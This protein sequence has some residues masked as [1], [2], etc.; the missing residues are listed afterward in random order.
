ME[1]LDKF[2]QHQ[3]YTF[4]QGAF[5]G[6]YGTPSLVPFLLVTSTIM[7]QM[8]STATVTADSLPTEEVKTA[9]GVSERGSA[10]CLVQGSTGL[11][12]EYFVSLAGLD[13][14]M[15]AGMNHMACNNT[16]C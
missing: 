2:F 15:Q 11:L 8:D 4:S 5:Q 10:K 13:R 16:H 9:R 1:V 12:P 7:G 14:Y 3:T 6:K